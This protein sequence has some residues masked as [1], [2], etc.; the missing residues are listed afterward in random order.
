MNQNRVLR[1]YPSP[2]GEC[3]LEGLY[4]DHPMG[5][6]DSDAAPFVY[7]N[8]VSS[9]DGRIAVENPRAG[10]RSAPPAIT[11]PRDWRLFQELAARADALIVSAAFVRGLAE[12]RS[13]EKLPVGQDAAFS[14]LHEWRR[15]RGMPP[16]PAIVILSRSLDVAVA[17]RCQSLERAVYFAVGSD[18]ALDHRAAVEATGARILI[19]GNGRQVEG[20]A[21]IDALGHEGFRRIYSIA[22]PRVLHTLLK[23][24]V[25]HR[26]Y[27]THFHRLLGGPSFDTLLEG[28]PLEPPASFVLRSIH[29]DRG[30]EGAAGQFFAAYDIARGA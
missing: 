2:Q 30:L 7:T 29:F 5:H 23:G 14:D 19:A 6:P 22:G 26:L 9:L 15:E 18:V 24:G 17:E 16:Q 27:L 8:F 3:T 25:L 1:L 12:G 13:H 28:D 11:N 21:L 10:R 20:R 4:L